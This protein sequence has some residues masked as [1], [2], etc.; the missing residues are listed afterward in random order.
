[1]DRDIK[2]KS[3]MEEA[4]VLSLHFG[5]ENS[6]PRIFKRHASHGQGKMQWSDGGL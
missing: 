3:K 2:A 6:L 5:D 4:L 1:M